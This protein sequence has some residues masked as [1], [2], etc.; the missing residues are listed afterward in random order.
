LLPREEQRKFFS[1]QK[2]HHHQRKTLYA[3]RDLAQPVHQPLEQ[4]RFLEGIALARS[5]VASL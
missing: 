1:G 3:W 2:R 4:R 5:R